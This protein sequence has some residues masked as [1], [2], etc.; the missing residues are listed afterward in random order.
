[1]RNA[2][3]IWYMTSSYSNTSVFF[4]PIVNEKPAFSKISTEV[5][6]KM[7]F[8]WPFSSDTCGRYAKADEK[9]SPFSSK[10]GYV[11]TGPKF[12]ITFVFLFLLGISAVLRRLW[13]WQPHRLSKRQSLSTTTVLFNYFIYTSHQSYSG[14]RSPGRSHSTYFSYILSYVVGSRIAFPAVIL[15][16]KRKDP[17]DQGLWCLGSILVCKE[18][19]SRLSEGG[20][21]VFLS[22]ES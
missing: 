21:T 4:R 3:S 12:C 1:M 20:S 17:S 7:R 9:K 15:F 19:G 11:W 10:K 2:S 16:S 13:R 18:S 14:L 5:F 6:E 22:Y 8:R